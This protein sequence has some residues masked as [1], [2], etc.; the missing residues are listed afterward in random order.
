M[1]IIPAHAKIGSN[2][3]PSD[4]ELLGESLILKHVS[5]IRQAQNYVALADRIPEKLSEQDEA[6]FVTDKIK[7]MMSCVKSLESTRKEEKEPFL[8][9]GQYVDTFFN[10]EK[11]K[12]ENAINKA[13]L[14]LGNFLKEQAA[15]EQKRRDDEAATLHKAAQDAMANAVMSPSVDSMEQAVISKG[16]ADF[17]VKVAS[18][19]VQTMAVAKG[20]YSTA[21]LKKEWVG[22]ITD[23][24]N[25]D[26][27]K[28]KPYIKV[29]ALQVAL[30]TYIK[31]GGRECKGCTIEE[32][33][34]TKVK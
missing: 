20:N 17:A 8:R 4:I 27:E 31:M 22:T 32:T 9:Q 5:L 3:P 14:P 34:T 11:V 19:P 15:I 7:E 29:D 18:V 28:L 1:A 2:N 24:A 12:L 6:N 30:N 13:N 23:I 26:I 21:S 16:V 33:I 25:I 10:D